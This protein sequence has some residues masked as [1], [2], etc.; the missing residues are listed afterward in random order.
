[1]VWA[2]NASVMGMEILLQDKGWQTRLAVGVLC[3]RRLDTGIDDNG[4]Q[5]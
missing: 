3:G 4:Y 2:E 5:L 1:M